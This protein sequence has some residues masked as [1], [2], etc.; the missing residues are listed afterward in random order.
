MAKLLPSEHFKKRIAERGV[1]WEECEQTISTPDRKFECGKGELGGIKRRYEKDFSDKT[2]IVV[3]IGEVLP[4]DKN[5]K[6][7]TAWKKENI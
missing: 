4:K 7:I 3:V 1:T 5:I 6:G 2:I